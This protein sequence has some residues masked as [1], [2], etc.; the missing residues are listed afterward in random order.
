MQIVPLRNI[1]LTRDVSRSRNQNRDTRILHP[2]SCLVLN[3]SDPRSKMRIL[4]TH[5]ICCLHVNISMCNLVHHWYASVHKYNAYLHI[6]EVCQKW[7]RCKKWC[8]PN[9]WCQ[10]WIQQSFPVV[11]AELSNIYMCCQLFLAIPATSAPS[12]HIWSCARRILIRKKLLGLGI[13]C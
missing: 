2:R 6:I 4:C 5:K 1:I 10:I 7:L 11:E 8:I 3:H 12:E 13:W 9:V